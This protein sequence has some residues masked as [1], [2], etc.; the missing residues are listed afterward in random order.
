MHP[1]LCALGPVTIY[2]FGF[3]IA[4]ATIVCSYL[5]GRDVQKIGQPKEAAYDF[6]FWMALSGIIGARI[7]Y[8]LLNLDLF[9][10]DPSEIW[11]LQNGGLAWQGGLV[12]ATAA[13]FFYLRK[14]RLPALKFLDLAIPYAALGQS[15]GR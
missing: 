5:F 2:S 7:F 15:I 13:A 4:V 11:K 3:M 12:F 1:V 14:R 10:A 8:I 9:T 6:V